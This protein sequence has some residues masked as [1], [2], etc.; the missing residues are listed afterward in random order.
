MDLVEQLCVSVKVPADTAV[1]L[2]GTEV[3]HAVKPVLD[4]WHV[5]LLLMPTAVDMDVS[6]TAESTI[7]PVGS[8]STSSP[9]PDDHAEPGKPVVPSSSVSPT[10]RVKEH[11]AAAVESVDDPKPPKPTAAPLYE[12]HVE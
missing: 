8:A 6:P 2:N 7:A 4:G 12:G 11:T 9:T 3:G 1:C 5:P 10:F